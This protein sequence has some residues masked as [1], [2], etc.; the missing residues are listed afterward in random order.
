MASPPSDPLHRNHDSSPF[1]PLFHRPT[2]RRWSVQP[3]RQIWT[4]SALIHTAI[5]CQDRLPTRF[6]H[7]RRF[8]ISSCFIFFFICTFLCWVM[9]SF[10]NPFT[11]NFVLL[12]VVPI[13][14]HIQFSGHPTLSKGLFW[15]GLKSSA[16]VMPLFTTDLVSN[17][18]YTDQAL[19][20]FKVNRVETFSIPLGTE[21][22]PFP[23]GYYVTLHV[24]TT[25]FRFGLLLEHPPLCFNVCIISG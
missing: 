22:S 16:W 6:L 20:L 14:F 17:P 3:T 11:G 13:L 10:G 23:L 24:G 15:T 7:L 2:L 25:F 4:L 5:C 9:V 8:V 18:P 1:N 21:N 19:A 12:F